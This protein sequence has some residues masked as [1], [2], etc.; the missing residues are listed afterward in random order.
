[1][2]GEEREGREGREEKEGEASLGAYR[3]A[4]SRSEMSNKAAHF[5][6]RL[7]SSPDAD[8]SLSKHLLSHYRTLKARAYE[9]TVSARTLTNENGS[10]PPGVS[11]RPSPTPEL[12]PQGEMFAKLILGP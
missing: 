11:P 10:P 6:T 4:W 1:M 2:G 8:L 9:K 12:A 3:R 7:P 5:T